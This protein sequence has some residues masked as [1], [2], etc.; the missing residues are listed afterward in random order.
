MKFMAL[1]LVALI[2]FAS[3]ARL[4]AHCSLLRSYTNASSEEVHELKKPPVTETIEVPI[5]FKLKPDGGAEAS[6]QLEY[7]L[8]PSYSS[9][10][11]LI[12]TLRAGK[13]EWRSRMVTVRKH[14]GRVMSRSNRSGEHVFQSQDGVFEF[15]LDCDAY[16]KFEDG[17]AVAPPTPREAARIRFVNG[18][19][20]R[21]EYNDETRELDRYDLL[22]QL[23]R[24]PSLPGVWLSETLQDLKRR[25]LSYDPL[26]ALENGQTF[27]V[28]KARTACP[29]SPLVC[30]EQTFE[31]SW[32]FDGALKNSDGN[33][34]FGYF[35]LGVSGRIYRDV[36]TREILEYQIDAVSLDALDGTTFG[37]GSTSGGFITKGH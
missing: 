7:R 15:S 25:G 17:P 31:A 21:R 1:S 12:E 30:E 19:S 5:E 22:Q 37:G 29:S 13:P 24:L 32:I 9:R 33:R 11:Q 27:K 36:R 34:R 4:T 23:A 35:A 28:T 2:S 6:F 8:A 20:R 16:D 10:I 3:E 26:G 18:P 14:D